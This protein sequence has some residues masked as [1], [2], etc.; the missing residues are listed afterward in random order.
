MNDGPARLQAYGDVLRRARRGFQ[1]PL[2]AG[3]RQG[4]ESAAGVFLLADSWDDVEARTALESARAAVRGLVCT[5]AWSY[6]DL[7]ELAW[8]MERCGPLAVLAAA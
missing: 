2:P 5:E 6:A 7:E 3:I 1:P 8:D 4:L